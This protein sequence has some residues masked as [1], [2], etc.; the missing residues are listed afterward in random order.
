MAAILWHFLF[1]YQK[2]SIWFRVETALPIRLKFGALD[3]YKITKPTNT[4][5]KQNGRPQGLKSCFVSKNTIWSIVGTALPILLKFG[6]RYQ[7]KNYKI[8]QIFF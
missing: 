1:F 3:Q 4:L 5:L 6:T 8:K 2:N 7:Y